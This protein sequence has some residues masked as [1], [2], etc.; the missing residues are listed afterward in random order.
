MSLHA[1]HALAERQHGIVHIRQ[2]RGLASIGAVRSAVRRGV[3]VE[4]RPHVYR[5]A[6]TPSTWHQAALAAVLVAGDDAVASHATAAALLGFE[7]FRPGSRTPLHVTV[8]RGR[9]PP[10]DQVAVHTTQLGP[11]CHRQVVARITV[12]DAARTLCDLDGH[13]PDWRLERVVDDALMRK[14]VSIGVLAEGH[15]ELRRGSRRSRAM[16]AILAERGGEWDDAESPGEARLV[17]W[18]VAAG[19]PRPVQQHEVDG[20]RVDLAY[21]DLDLYIEYDGFD[22]HSTRT[23][24]DRDRRRGNRLALRTGATVLRFTSSSTRE[25]V[26]RD[27]TAARERR[28]AEA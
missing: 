10:I 9:Q 16:H 26:I 24:F 14:L 3:L 28:T 2:A 17:R 8:P 27:V 19:L 11:G 12:T 25:E 22:P 15:A 5:F 18:L 4:V 23:R 13:V 20:Y 7:G 1:L 6:G 21:P